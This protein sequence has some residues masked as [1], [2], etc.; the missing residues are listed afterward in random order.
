MTD[1]R[2]A[3]IG[4]NGVSLHVAQAGRMGDP[5]LLLLH[6]FPE[7]WQTWREPATPAPSAEACACKVR[8]ASPAQTALDPDRPGN[9]LSADHGGDVLALGVLQNEAPR[10]Q[11][12]FVRTS[13]RAN[14]SL[15][16][17]SVRR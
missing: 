12:E 14:R 1:I 7:Y 15:F 13:I 17:L 6:G 16:S 4:S 2:T 3:L 9:P 11:V 10:N 5:P 8:L